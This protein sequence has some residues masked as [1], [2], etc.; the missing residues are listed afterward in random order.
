MQ[1]HR[2]FL[3]NLDA[4]TKLLALFLLSAQILFTT[5]YRML[6]AY[7]CITFLAL[8]LSPISFRTAAKQLRKI[9]WFVLFITC[10]NAVTVSGIVLYEFAGVYLT[11]EGVLDGLA[12]SARLGIVLL[13]SFVFT[14][15]TRVADI[16]D[17][18]EEF[19]SP[20]QSRLGSFISVFG[21]TMN[22]VP[23]LI[24]SAQR[25]KAAQRAR[26][27]DVDS[28]FTSQVRFASEAALP[29]FVAAFRASQ[30]LADAM[31]ARCYDPAARRT[32]IRIR[33]MGLA[34]WMTLLFLLCLPLLV[35]L[36]TR[37][38]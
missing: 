35:M 15:T 12:L 36:L 5:D 21:L 4:K 3:E 17:S 25:I 38:Q 28:S 29:L 11:K 1:F 30:H 6:A 24:Q 31:D 8:G 27:A 34:D 9:L 37:I 7:G 26:G 18:I 33:K 10:I 22:F 20:F 2:R 14:R 16:V 32:S 23:L 13:L 19:L